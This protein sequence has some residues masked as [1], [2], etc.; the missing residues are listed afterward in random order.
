MVAP[1]VVAP[2]PVPVAAPLVPGVPA[3]APNVAFV[4]GAVAA[5]PV[6]TAP[7]VPVAPVKTMTAKAAAEGLTY[8]AMLAANWTDALM[9]QH[10]Y[11]AA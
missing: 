6:P 4:A 8:E 2:A 10:G 1:P 3:P 5:P 9:I 7:S 11:L